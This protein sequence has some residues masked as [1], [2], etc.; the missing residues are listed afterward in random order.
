[1]ESMLNRSLENLFCIY[2]E[3]HF[4]SSSSWHA[5]NLKEKYLAFHLLK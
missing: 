1:M 4:S 5:L 2:S 3:K